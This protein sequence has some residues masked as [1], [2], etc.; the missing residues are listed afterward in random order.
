MTC[1]VPGS[2]TTTNHPTPKR[3]N[4]AA[5]LAAVDVGR[6]AFSI[7][8]WAR[9]RFVVFTFF[10]LATRFTALLSP[11]QGDRAS[12][13]AAGWPPG[14]R[15]RSHLNPTHPRRGVASCL[16]GQIL[17][18]MPVLGLGK[19]HTCK[20]PDFSGPFPIP[21][22]GFGVQLYT[23]LAASFAAFDFSWQVPRLPN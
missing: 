17:T 14:R 11:P 2:G 10:R 19:L 15:R 4:G 13:R 23:P 6:R 7:Q 9:A 16:F 1:T 8:D 20:V 12:L 21:N 5:P 3:P 18:G 22:S